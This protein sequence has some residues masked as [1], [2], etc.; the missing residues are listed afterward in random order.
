MSTNFLIVWL[1]KYTTIKLSERCYNYFFDKVCAAICVC[2]IVCVNRM[3]FKID[4]LNIIFK[5]HKLGRH[6]VLV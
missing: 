3:I 4:R 5:S 6:L 2:H 1:W